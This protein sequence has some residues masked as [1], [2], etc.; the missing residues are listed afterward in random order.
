MFGF[1]SGYAGDLMAAGT[2]VVSIL[3]RS[4]VTSVVSLVDVGDELDVIWLGDRWVARRN[5]MDV[6]TLTWNAKERGNP[7]PR[8]GAPLW[9][10]DDGVLHVERVVVD[11]D[12]IV[13]NLA[14]YVTPVVR[15]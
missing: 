4:S 7:D 10:L 15:S 5:G 1:A 3:R 2:P 9:M 6:G 12:D 8:T 11:E 13:V 14:G